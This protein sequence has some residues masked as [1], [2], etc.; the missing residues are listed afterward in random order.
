MRKALVVGVN[1]YQHASPLHGCVNDAIAVGDVLERH[2]DGELNFDCLRMH[3][4]KTGSAI[5]RT[6]LK[7][8][9]R[10]LFETDAQIALLYFAGHG[11]VEDTGGYL[12]T[13]DSTTF[14]D[15]LALSE[16]LMLANASPANHKIIIL[17]SCHSGVAGTA[18]RATKLA[19][20]SEG[21]TILT[22]STEDQYAMEVNG[23]GVFTSLL[24]DALTGAAANLVGDITLS[25]VYAHIDQ[26][27]GAWEQRPMFKTNVKQ[28]VSLRKVEPAIPLENL[29]RISELFPQP[30]F[31]FPLDPS[32]E[33]E[34]PGRS[35]DMPPPDPTNTATFAVLQQY[36][37]KNLLIP[38]DAPSMW[39]A[40]M[41]NRGCRLTPLGEHY[42]RLADK[43]RI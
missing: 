34:L 10:E 28:F 35:G 9:V 1:Y 4:D 30:D 7:A 25:G 29:R 5:T 12:L 26:A 40:A 41:G 6:A 14:D 18:T 39:H 16:V 17:D 27:L 21:M 37:R 8:Q 43:G 2:G 15:G 32:Y 42:R 20:L 3:A 33:P 22:A 38:D 11:H 36:N 13:S 31:I 19:T 23:S 24:V